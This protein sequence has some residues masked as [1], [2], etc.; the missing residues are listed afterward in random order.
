MTSLADF[1]PAS[2]PIRPAATVMLV[3]QSSGPLEVFMM[4]RT[5]KAAFAGGM[6]VFPGGAV[7]AADSSHPDT[8]NLDT[9]FEMASIRE[10]FEEAGVLLACDG[11]GRTVKFDD[12]EVARRFAE[13][14]HVVHAG[15]R[16]MS[17]IL[18]AEGL[19]ARHDHLSWV[20]HWI[21]PF[22][23]VRRFDTRFYV[24]AMPDDQEPLH[25]DVET[26]DSLWVEPR[27]ALERASS[28]DLLMLPPTMANLR[29][30]A[31]HGT[32]DDV[33]SAAREIG[34]PPRILPKV[35]WGDD[36]RITALLMPG[37]DGYDA[38]PER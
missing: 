20:A 31:E 11:S 15:E 5:T 6:Y 29:F 4:R 17:S 7:D 21:T 10:C 30:L 24:A 28:D 38:I 3:R 9:S 16:T 25:D 2:V 23:E 1:D 12:P 19:S 8:S 14:R 32:V 22:G 36:G 26:V 18:G 34:T 27:V 13:Y 35:V 37:D 33:M